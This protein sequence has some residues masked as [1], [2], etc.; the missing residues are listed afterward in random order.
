VNSY[1]WLEDRMELLASRLGFF[2]C[3]GQDADGA[4]D[5]IARARA[6]SSDFEPDQL[7]LLHYNEAYAR[8]LR[9]E[10]AKASAGLVLAEE[11][12][13]GEPEGVVLVLRLMTPREYEPPSPTANVASVEAEELH[14]VLQAQRAVYQ[15]YA[16]AI[17]EEE[18]LELSGSLESCPAASR[19]LGWTALT[20]FG[21]IDVAEQLL[22]DALSEDSACESELA[23]IRQLRDRMAEP[24]DAAPGD[25]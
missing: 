13:A 2:C 16:G 9:R 5:A 7:M 3:V 14:D 17:D 21:R 6:F 1:S 22:A 4:L 11:A 19:L 8:S 12:L 25:S 10:W 23:W 15:A 24:D 20:R 18:F